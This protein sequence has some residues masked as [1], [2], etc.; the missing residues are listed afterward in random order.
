MSSPRYS[1]L[2]FIFNLARPFAIRC[3]PLLCIVDSGFFPALAIRGG[4]VRRAGAFGPFLELV[5]C[6]DAVLL[7]N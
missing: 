3:P 4:T 1:L 2:F 7:P 5:D 6:V